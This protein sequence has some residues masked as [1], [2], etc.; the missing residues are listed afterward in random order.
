MRPETAS[1]T[2]PVPLGTGRLDA[3][4]RLQETAR[5]DSFGPLGGASKLRRRPCRA[6][7]GFRRRSSLRVAA[8]VATLTEKAFAA[9]I[10]D[11]A[12]QAWARPALSLYRHKTDRK[13]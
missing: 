5:I 11:D 1:A 4:H 10:D 7:S 12:E 8:A 9:G 2:R 3:P 13:P 6:D